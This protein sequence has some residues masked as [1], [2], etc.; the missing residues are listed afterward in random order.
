MSS[1]DPKYSSPILVDNPDRI[2]AQA[3]C[4]IACA[5][6]ALQTIAIIPIQS[7]AGTKPYNPVIVLSDTPYPGLK[8]F[9]INGKWN[10]ANVLFIDNW[11]IDETVLE[12]YRGSYAVVR[13]GCIRDKE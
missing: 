13:A 8:R 11:K 2:I 7:V 6:V 4:L 10:E 9:P 1:A 5:L 12:N 3:I